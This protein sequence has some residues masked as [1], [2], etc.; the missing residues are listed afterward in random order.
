MF[1]ISYFI[2]INIIVSQLFSLTV[3][4]FCWFMEQ[5][6]IYGVSCPLK[7]VASFAVLTEKAFDHDGNLKQPKELSINKV[8]HGMLLTLCWLIVFWLQIL[9]STSPLQFEDFS[10]CPLVVLHMFS[11]KFDFNK[12]R[13][14]LAV[15]LIC[16]EH[17]IFSC[18]ITWKRPSI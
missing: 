7:Y 4:I 5:C 15:F 8:G 6:G 18:S 2:Y 12:H 3:I 14:S 13:Y 17:H 10:L 9:F 16:I 11:F 1:Y